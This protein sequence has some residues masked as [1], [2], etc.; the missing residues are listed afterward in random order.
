VAPLWRAVPRRVGATQEGGNIGDFPT[1]AEESPT[2][3]VRSFLAQAVGPWLLRPL[4][5]MARAKW[6]KRTAMGGS[7]RSDVRAANLGAE[8]GSTMEP[9]IKLDSPTSRASRT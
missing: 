5:R 6:R 8:S 3:R 4:T 2:V 1:G 7:Q 9:D